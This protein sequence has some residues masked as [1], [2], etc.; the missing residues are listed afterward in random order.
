MRS[1]VKNN[2]RSRHGGDSNAKLEIRVDPGLDQ[3]S[4]RRHF[5][6]VKNLKFFKLPNIGGREPGQYDQEDEDRDVQPHSMPEIRR[7]VF[8]KST[9]IAQFVS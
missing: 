5:G 4:D 8:L 9:M 6:R 3:S 7:V 1:R 2:L